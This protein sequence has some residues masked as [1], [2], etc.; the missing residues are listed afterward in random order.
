MPCRF[1]RYPIPS[2]AT[3]RCNTNSKGLAAIA[4]AIGTDVLQSVLR[5]PSETGGWQLGDLDLE[6]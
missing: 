1:S 6:R 5:Y 3:L 4:G 2:S